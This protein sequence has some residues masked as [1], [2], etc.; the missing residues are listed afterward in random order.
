[1]SFDSLMIKALEQA[2][3]AFEK[4]EIPVGCVIVNSKNNKIIAESCNKNI[5]LKDPTAHAEILAIREACKKL[6][7]DRLTFCD[8]YVTLE[9]CAMCAAAISYAGIRRLYY[10]A[11]NLKEGAIENGA[12]IYVNKF[13]NY[14]PEVY[15]GI[16]EKEC[17]LLLKDFFKKKR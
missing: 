3:I 17:G 8:L 9:P 15:G 7:S 10:G 4:D 16:L 13:V 1:M 14:I 5:F 12:Q 6:N 2:K 11:N